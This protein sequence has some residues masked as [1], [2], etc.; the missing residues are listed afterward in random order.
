[1][2]RIARSA[3]F[4]AIALSVASLATAQ[5]RPASTPPFIPSASLV[6]GT[7][8]GEIFQID[9]F[10]PPYFA[11]TAPGSP[12]NTVSFP[13]PIFTGLGISTAPFAFSLNLSSQSVLLKSQHDS[14]TVTLVSNGASFTGAVTSPNGATGTVEGI[15]VSPNFFVLSV[16]VN[17]PVPGPCQANFQGHALIMPSMPNLL[18]FSMQGNN[19]ACNNQVVRGRLS[20]T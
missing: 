16:V 13:I 1:M 6:D 3:L 8:S 17:E 4:A 19:A 11:T 15:A 5:G 20:K 12:T 14:I 18:V 2:R 9:A 10:S 7:W